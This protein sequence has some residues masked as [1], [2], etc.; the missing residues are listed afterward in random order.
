MAKFYYFT[1]NNKKT[2]STIIQ[3]DED[4]FKYDN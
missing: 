3:K 1:F 4:E 2:S